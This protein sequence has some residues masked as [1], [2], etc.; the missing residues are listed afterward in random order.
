MIRGKV[1]YAVIGLALVTA[2]AQVA[3]AQPRGRRGGFG[4]G[5]SSVRLATL[6]QVQSD[7]KLSDEQKSKVA[8]IDDQLATSRRDLFQQRPDD[9]AE[10]REKMEKL[11]HDAAAKLADVLDKDQLKRLAGIVIQVSGPQALNDPVVDGQLSL[12][13]EQKT[14]LNDV[15]A[16]HWQAVGDAMS[17]AQDMSREERRAKMSELRDQAGKDLMAV[18]T[19][20]QQTQFEQLKGEPIDIDMSQLRGRGRRGG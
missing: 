13:D 12:S 11:N 1:T 17:Q 10:L 8:D 2:L 4:F 15:R 5:A 20:D 7:L 14:K 19:P 3:S 9:M 6:G 18:L 16:K